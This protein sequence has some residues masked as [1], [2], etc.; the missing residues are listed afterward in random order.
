MKTKLIFTAICLLLIMLSGCDRRNPHQPLPAEESTLQLSGEKF[1]LAQTGEYEFIQTAAIS[2]TEVH[3]A[4]YAWRIT[5]SDEVL[6][7][8]LATD[9]EGW[10]Y[11]YAAGADTSVPLDDNS[12]NRT[13]WTSDAIQNW[14][15]ASKNGQLNRIICKAEV[16]VKRPGRS[17]QRLEQVFRTDRLVSTQIIVPFNIG[18]T[19][20]TGFHASLR[21]QVTDIFVEGMYAHHFMYRINTLDNALNVLQTGNW[22]SSIEGENIRELYLTGLTP[23]Q[24]GEYT[25]L[26]VYVV[27]RQGVEEATHKTVHFRVNGNFHPGALIYHK[28][29]SAL[30]QHH[31]SYS[32][33]GYPSS[34]FFTNGNNRYNNHL[35]RSGNNYCAITSPDLVLRLAFGFRGQYGTINLSGSTVNNDDPFD[36]LINLCL[37]ELTSIP[38]YSGIRYFDL[39]MNGMPFPD[40]FP[41]G[42]TSI[43]TRPDNSQWRRVRYN[44]AGALTVNLRY[45]G[46]GT[47]HIQ[48][49]VVDEQGVYDP[50]PAE[51]TIELENLIGDAERSGILIVD[52]DS[53]HTIF[54]PEDVVDSIYEQITPTAYGPVD[55]I[56]IRSTDIYYDIRYRRLSS[57][58]LQQYKAVI[59]H[60]DNPTQTSFL[61]QE[62]D[63]LT[64]YLNTGGKVIFSGGSNLTSQLTNITQISSHL[65]VNLMGPNAALVPYSLT[66]SIFSKPY[67][68]GAISETGYLNDIPLNLTDPFC[69]I[70]NTVQGLGTVTYFMDWYGNSHLYKFDCKQPST[71]NYAPSQETYDFLI[72][73]HVAVRNDLAGGGKLVLFGFPLSYMDTTA[74]TTALSA[75]LNNLF[76]GN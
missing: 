45:P 55:E 37:D 53:H 51:M 12:C 7:Q 71:E 43:I 35:F 40:L 13:I 39:R 63:A 33:S 62:I 9:A 57:N 61:S 29:V 11:H 38:Y 59:F 41:Y 65:Y 27:S 24:T 72:T 1:E 6:P 23:N 70:L 56:D 74:V 31:Y 67:I 49:S 4:L 44:G 8:G 22:L 69:T 66:N 15:F 60:T 58:L 36:S 2:T 50:T 73:K 46:A 32:N 5:T 30:G 16:R 20:G 3:D 42:T 17:E 68:V 76:N 28:L 21:E 26:E 48:A 34:F 54:A 64:I 10:L 18:A 52:D 47:Y 14:T 75:L 25:Q 19:V